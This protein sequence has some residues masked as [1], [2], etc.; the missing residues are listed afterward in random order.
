MKCYT[1]PEI[2]AQHVRFVEKEK[3][4]EVRHEM[5]KR[6]RRLLLKKRRESVK[7]L[8]NIKKLINK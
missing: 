6:N 1:Y 8:H 7:I 5:E 3:E 4:V 2:D